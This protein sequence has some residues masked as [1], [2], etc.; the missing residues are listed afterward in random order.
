MCI[1]RYL[2]SYFYPQFKMHITSKRKTTL[3]TQDFIL[4]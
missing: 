2:F 3:G 1:H 4:I